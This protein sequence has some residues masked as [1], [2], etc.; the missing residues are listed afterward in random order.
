MNFNPPKGTVIISA[1]VVRR[2]AKIAVN[3]N[4]KNMVEKRVDGRAARLGYVS[5]VASYGGGTFY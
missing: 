2:K 5:G 3:S 1:R 4:S